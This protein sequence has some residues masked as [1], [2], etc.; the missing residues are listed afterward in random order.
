[1]QT[2]PK[3]ESPANAGFVAGLEQEG[4]AGDRRD[5]GRAAPRHA[6]RLPIEANEPLGAEER[7]RQ[8]PAPARAAS[9]RMQAAPWPAAT[10]CIGG[11]AAVHAA[12]ARGARAAKRPPRGRRA[13]AGP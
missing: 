10:S 9:S 1:M 3:P 7:R 2:F 4:D 5:M 13:K 8:A 6:P 11:R 12:E